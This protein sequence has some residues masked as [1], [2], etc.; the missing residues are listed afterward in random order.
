MALSPLRPL[1]TTVTLPRMLGCTRQRTWKVPA[2]GKETVKVGFLPDTKP[3]ET[4]FLPVT[5]VPP[6]GPGTAGLRLSTGVTPPH[7]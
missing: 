3:E 7:Q 1:A 4:V 6:V 5:T 2:F